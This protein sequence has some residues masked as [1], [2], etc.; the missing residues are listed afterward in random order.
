MNVL[1]ATCEDKIDQFLASKSEAWGFTVHAIVKNQLSLAEHLD[2]STQ[3]DTVVLNR[4]LP[5]PLSISDVLQE[6][7][8]KQIRPI[9]LL[10]GEEDEEVMQ[11]AFSLGMYDF[12]I[13]QYGPKQL[14][15]ILSTPTTKEAA[16]QY[17]Q[18]FYPDFVVAETPPSVET[19]A[20][21]EFFAIS[22]Q[23]PNGPTGQQPLSNARVEP[24]AASN[25]HIGQQPLPNTGIESRVA[26]AF[27]TTPIHP[28]MQ[29]APSVLAPRKPLTIAVFS[30][31]GG[32]GKTNVI[33]NTGLGLI[34]NGKT[35]VIVDTD[36]HQGTVGSIL[37]TSQHF[38][39]IDWNNFPDEM[40]EASILRSL[41]QHK[42]GLYCLPSPI[43]YI[44]HPLKEE[45]FAKIQRN[46]SKCFSA[47]LFDTDGNFT[48]SN[49]SMMKNMD[50][51][52]YVMT[53]DG[54]SLER[55]KQTIERLVRLGIKQES[56]RI[57]LNDPH[58]TGLGGVEEFIAKKMAPI[59]LGSLSYSRHLQACNEEGEPILKSRPKDPF[60]KEMTQVVN[61]LLHGSMGQPVAA[62]TGKTA[63]K[64][65][66]KWSI[67][68]FGR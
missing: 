16:L 2:Q 67:P 60:S 44:G 64:K 62:M 26:A 3:I 19:E 4:F 48:K 12:L 6:I 51:V 42:S 25:T 39:V 23:A 43:D 14:Q 21:E 45:L 33:I 55:H 28:V 35:T 47:I 61:H 56:I 58:N 32:V 1:L 31:K 7:K 65:R 66:I 46:L 29:P 10:V 53:A 15:S 17:V 52:L 30:S 22:T 41:G 5:G 38:S 57:I 63:K 27:D 50:Y 13:G 24:Q 37:K 18:T 20:E 34:E 68:F 54:T 8:E 49:I 36:V 11:V 40:D 59:E 9:L